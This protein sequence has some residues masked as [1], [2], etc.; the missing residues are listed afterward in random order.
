[1]VGDPGENVGKMAC[2]LMPLSL[3]VSIREYMA[4]P[5]AAGIGPGK[6]IVLAA[7]GDAAQGASGR[8][9]VKIETT[10]DPKQVQQRRQHLQPRRLPSRSRSGKIKTGRI[11]A[12]VCDER[13]FAGTRPPAATF[14][15]SSDRKRR[16]PAS[17]IA[18]KALDRIGQLY[19]ASSN[20]KLIAET[21]AAWAEQNV[22]KLSRKSELAA[23]FRYMR[24]R[25]TALTRCFEDEANVRRNPVLDR[26]VA[27][28]PRAGVGGQ[29]SKCGGR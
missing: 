5:R 23:A 21:P 7:D 26:P 22:A 24:A 4:A 6:Q 11:W 13:P 28:A 19:A 14:F 25:W 17:P 27:G 1:V 18:K 29:G 2:G 10:N 12:Y 20:H 9:V 16:V 8:I 15:Y 3:A